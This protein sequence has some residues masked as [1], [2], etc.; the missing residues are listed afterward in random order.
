MLLAWSGISMEP[1][2][3]V[4]EYFSGHGQVSAAFREQGQSVASYDITYCG[5]PMDFL[6]PGGFSILS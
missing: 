5:K 2:H 1:E 3:N 4:V 6:E